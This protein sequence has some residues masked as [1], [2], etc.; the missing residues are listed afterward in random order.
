M[1][2]AKI[3]RVHLLPRRSAKVERIKR[4]AAEHKQDENRSC[5]GGCAGGCYDGVNLVGYQPVPDLPGALGGSALAE[6]LS[7]WLAGLSQQGSESDHC[8]EVEFGG[9]RSGS[10]SSALPHP[11]TPRLLAL[12]RE[13]HRINEAIIDVLE[14]MTGGKAVRHDSEKP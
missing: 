3:I 2:K 9:S 4:E 10:L 12:F 7:G 13:S 11:K 1:S 8:M 5:A 6:A 14:E